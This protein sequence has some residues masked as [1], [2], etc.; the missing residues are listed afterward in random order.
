M[1]DAKV[2]GEAIDWVIRLR[3]PVTADWGAFTLW[4]EASPDNNAAYDQV[5]S[6]D[7]D[8]GDL[9]S[10]LPAT[11]VATV[12]NDNEP[13][14]FRRYGAVAA[15]L[16]VAVGAYPA[17]QIAVPT[18]AVETALGEQRTISMEDGTVIDLNGGTRLTLDRRNSRIASLEAGEARFTVSH[19][20]QAPFAV[21]AGDAL[22]QD[23]GTVFNIRLGDAQTDVAVEEGSVLFN[24]KGAAVLLT[25]GTR[26]QMHGNTKP[27]LTKIEPGQVSGWKSGRLEYLAT[28]LVTV[29]ADL[30]RAI[31]KPVVMESGLSR[32]AFTGTI[33]LGT[34]RDDQAVESIATLMGLKATATAD[35][36]QFSAF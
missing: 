7:A 9:V 10:A 20:A 29:A 18:Y 36:W 33:M 21:K 5:A 16:L 31:G 34:R 14:F 35:G 22:I 28:P 2:H 23:V 11:I 15:A 27:V 4:L 30:T 1:I 3:D 26:L 6:A 19:N 13:S 25:K 24:P 8:V 17:Y 12:A 32:R